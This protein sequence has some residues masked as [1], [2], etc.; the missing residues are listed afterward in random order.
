LIQDG[1]SQYGM[2][3]FD[4]CILELFQE[5]LVEYEVAKTN[6]SNPSEFDL[7]IQGITGGAAETSTGDD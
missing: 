5:D 6:T 7:A 4:Q 2:Q 3:T 1:R